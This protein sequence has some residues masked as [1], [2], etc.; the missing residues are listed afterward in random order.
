MTGKSEDGDQQRRLNSSGRQFY[1]RQTYSTS[2]I[3]TSVLD[4]V[5]YHTVYEYIYVCMYVCMHICIYTHM[6]TY[7]WTRVAFTNFGC[8]ICFIHCSVS[9][10]LKAQAW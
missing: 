3:H 2:A 6:N 1:N 5:T 9:N 4:L 7:Y 10:I 8:C